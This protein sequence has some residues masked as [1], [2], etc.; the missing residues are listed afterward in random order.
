[1]E[2]KMCDPMT[3]MAGAS[4][5]SGLIGADAASSAAAT[6]AA[7]GQQA[8]TG[9]Q[10]ALAEQR[11]LMQPYVGAGETALQ[12]LVAGTAPGG[13]FAKPYELGSALPEMGTFKAGESEAQTF[14]RDQALKA[15]QEQMQRGG[16][17]LSSN[18]IVGAGQTAAKI[19]SEYEQQAFNQW[20]QQ[21]QL[22]YGQALTGRQTALTEQQAQRQA[23][24]SPLEYL[25][26][27]GQAGAAGTA[28]AVGTSAGNIGNLQTG[29]GN[30]QAA[31]QVGQAGALAGGIG[32]VGQ[33]MF[34]Q[35]LLKPTAS[36]VTT[37]PA[38]NQIPTLATGLGGSTQMGTGGY[39][40]MQ[41]PGTTFTLGQQY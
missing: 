2:Q 6:Q 20:L 9:Q 18:A 26:N 23:Q 19:G 7:T 24:L 39:T 8:I 5:V 4:V 21:Q 32:N 10:Q 30:V 41:Y 38:S 28:G 22:G 29:I 16:Q 37:N 11:K 25:T 12:Q 40:Q 31:G 33:M 17:G 35:D 1:L 15:M 13:E 3:I 27:I 36:A 14:A 34:L